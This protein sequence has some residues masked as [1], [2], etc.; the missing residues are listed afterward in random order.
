MENRLLELCC[1]RWARYWHRQGIRILMYHDFPSVSGL[2]DALT[3]Q[4]AH[5]A[6]YY[7]VVTLTD[8][9]RYLREETALPKNALAVTVDDGNRD[10]LLNGYP[11][12]HAH[13]IPV[14]VFLVSGFLDGQMWLWWDQV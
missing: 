8:I 13:K 7:N 1:I 6:R 3:K 2:Q 10:F 5:I 11:I 12:F 14:S 9:G 4:C